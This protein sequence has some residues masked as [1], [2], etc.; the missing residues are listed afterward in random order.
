MPRTMVT[1]TLT[2]S[3]SLD[4]ADRR[5]AIAG[6]ISRANGALLREGFPTVTVKECFTPS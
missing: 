6:A 4:A 2:A 3:I 5:A 1:L